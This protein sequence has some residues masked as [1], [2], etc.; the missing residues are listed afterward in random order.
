[1]VVQCII[2]L[3]F[4]V[5]SFST[6]TTQFMRFIVYSNIKIATK[7]IDKSCNT[8]EPTNDIL[9][10]RTVL[11]SNL[12]LSSYIS[13]IISSKYICTHFF[14]DYF[15]DTSKSLQYQL[16]YHFAPPS[17]H[18]YRSITMFPLCHPPIRLL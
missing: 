5:S 18:H 13:S 11:L 1:M 7:A 9:R 14:L 4:I 6:Q 8:F 10:F 2:P 12:S 17:S 15:N 16:L 3:S